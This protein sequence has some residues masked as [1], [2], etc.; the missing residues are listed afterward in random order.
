MWFTGVMIVSP[1]K[2][3]LGDVLDAHGGLARWN[4]FDQL[5]ASIVS[6]GLLY[7]LKGQ[8][9]DRQ[10]RQ[11]RVGLREVRTC[12]QPFGSPTDA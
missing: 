9:Q 10:Q 5:E 6:G 11:V 7:A 2:V 4:G 1:V 8:S 12:L 3:L